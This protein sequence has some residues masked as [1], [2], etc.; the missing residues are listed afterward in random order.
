MA[1]SWTIGS[2]ADCDLI[3][4]LPHVSAV[5]C[6]LTQVD[7]GY[8]VEDLGSTNGTYLRGER[9]SGQVPVK[10]G[11]PVT[12]GRTI[13]MPWPPEHNLG[14]HQVP[15]A[16]LL[17]PIPSS[18][19][20][21]LPMPHEG[22]S[23]VIGRD[24]ACDTVINQPMVSGRHSR[25]FCSGGKIFVED[26]GSANGTLVDGRK[27]ERATAVVPGSTI[28]LG[29]YG[30]M[31]AQT[32]STATLTDT[33]T[34]MPAETAPVAATSTVSEVGEPVTQ[35]DGHAWLPFVLLI[36][37]P[38]LALLVVVALR[39]SAGT[40][41]LA[42]DRAM[43]AA[44]F[45][46][47][48]EAIWLGLSA[49]AFVGAPRWLPSA[50]GSTRERFLRFAM[51]LGFCTFQSALA[52]VVVAGGMGLRGPALPMLAVT[53]LASGVGLGLGVVVTELSRRNGEAW[54]AL[55]VIVLA[56]GLFG[57]Y[58]QRPT[59]WTRPIA[60]AL[61]SRWAFEGLVLLEL[62][63]VPEPGLDRDPAE[64]HFPAATERMGPR[65]DA[66][67]LCGMCVGLLAAAMFI[68][69]PARP[70]AQAT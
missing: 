45:W 41:G 5:H 64:E 3:I 53:A 50:S 70:R 57:G 65:A 46:L 7:D 66:I 27:I 17:S 29:S 1:T 12:L 2:S 20:E 16:Q 25:L 22:Q 61:P 37:A 51:L 8:L 58:P 48:L 31:L 39:S 10:W 56:C 34:H 69:E 21:T 4:K 38:L 42:R 13:A 32:R 9:L 40:A 15:A 67:A 68:S 62:S 11:D 26:L 24:S 33:S 6:R 23:I 52:W 18:L 49:A 44:L 14:T 54:V 43:V 47:G 59:T 36:H 30:V 60:S 28:G 55:V 35:P 63:G 19:A